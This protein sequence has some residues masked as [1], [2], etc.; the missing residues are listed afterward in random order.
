MVR[1]SVKQRRRFETRIR[2]R[3]QTICALLCGLTT[4]I[5]SAAAGGAVLPIDQ[6]VA[7]VDEDVVMLSE[8]ERQ[9][10]RVLSQLRQ[11]GTEV[12]PSSVIEKQILERLILQKLQLQLADRSG[13]EVDEETLSKT[14]AGIAGDNGLS[15]AEFRKILEEDGFS[16]RHFRDEIRE[17]LTITRLRQREVQ[18]R[19]QVSDREI[20]NQL[21]N[22]HQEGGIET[23]YRLLHILVATSEEADQEETT[24]RLKRVQKV[25]A[26]VND[27]E[28]FR[29]IAVAVSDGQQALDG[30]DLGWRKASQLPTLFMSF[31]LSARKGDVSEV[32]RSP[33][34]F[35]V[36]KLDGARSG[37]QVVVNQTKSQHILIKPNE[38]TSTEDALIRLEQLKLRLEGGERFDELARSHSDDRGSAMEGGDLGWLSP[39]DLVPE[40]EEVMNELAINAISEP[41]E[42]QFGWHV[43]Q[44]LDRRDYDGT[45]EV[46]RAKARDI[47]RQRKGEEELQAWLRRLRDEAYVEYRIPQ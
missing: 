7:I 21:S 11:Q 25:L 46:R 17:E 29:E 40:F 44:V 13:V 15:M 36:I 27:G 47:I 5:N 28:D 10:D 45:E 12:P 20:D 8:L 43:V 6:I 23:E 26:R 30:G 4:L 41:F 24:K 35:H 34:G 32:I 39:G 31:A 37:E 42:T 9:R 38:L 22:I 2:Q 33:S 19:V 3:L 14:I 16:F 1:M 18:N